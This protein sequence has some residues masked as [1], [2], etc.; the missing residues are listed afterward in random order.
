MGSV[1]PICG[2]TTKGLFH[3]GNQYFVSRY[4][5]KTSLDGKNFEPLR[6]DNGEEQVFAGNSNGC[7]SK[8]NRFDPV[9]AR[10]VRLQIKD[11]TER[12][13]LKWDVLCASN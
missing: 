13:A 9:F 7:E 2:V 6:Q 3:E 5:I 10:H 4:V 12:P 8:D 11:C 1:K